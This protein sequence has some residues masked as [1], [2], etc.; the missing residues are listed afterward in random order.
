MEVRNLDV[1]S[2]SPLVGAG[3]YY[4]AALTEAAMYRGHD[5]FIVGGANSAGQGAMFYS[6][7]ARK[8][9]LVVRGLNLDAMSD[10]LSTRIR[11]TENIDVLT[12][13]V[14]KEA[15]GTNRLEALTLKDLSSGE[16]RKVPASAVFIF[17]GQAPRTAVLASL[18]ALDNQGFVLT[19]QDVMVHHK[20]PNDWTPDRDP[21]PYETSVPGIFAAGDARHGS[22]KRIAS[23]VGEGSSAISMVHRYLETV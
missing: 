21:F 5:I 10:Y 12:R 23:A 8:V 9:T 18:V 4:G 3:V 16:T 22:G 19:G 17:I 13:T 20:R 1:P 11:E 2:L 6:R 7:Y 14:I 15:W